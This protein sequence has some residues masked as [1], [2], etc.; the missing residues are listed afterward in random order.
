VTLIDAVE[1]ER[2]LAL[3]DGLPQ[4]IAQA[5]A[6][7]QES[8]VG[9]TSY[10]RFYKQQWSELME[11]DDH[12]AVASLPDYLN[13]S[14]WTT[15]AI[16]YQAIRDKHEATANLLLLWSFLNNKD[17]WY[18]LFTTACRSSPVAA[19][20]L[21]G[22][23]GEI[24]SNDTAFSQA[25]QLLRNYSLVE[26]VVETRSYATHPVV[27]QWAYHSQARC[28]NTE[29]SRL[30]VVTVGWSV[31]G[32]SNRDYATLQRRLLPHAQACSSVIAKN[33]PGWNYRGHEGNHEAVDEKEEQEAVLDAI[34]L[35][36]NLYV[37]QGKLSEAEQMYEWALRGQEEAFGPTHMPTLQTVNNLGILYYNQGKLG[38]A[39]QMYKRALQGKEETFG[40]HHTSTLDTVNNL[41]NLYRNQGKLAEAGQMYERALRGKKEAHGLTHTSTLQTVNNLGNLYADQGKLGEAEQMYE[42]A[43]R[44]MEQALGPN[45]TSTLNT[46][47]NLGILYKKQGKLDEAEQMYKRALRGYEEAF[48]ATH[49]LTLDLVTNLGNLYKNQGKM[50]EAERMYKQALQGTKEALGP[51][52]TSTLQALS[53]LGILY[54]NQSKLG[55]AEQMYGRALQGY[56]EALGSIHMPTLTTINNLGLLYTNQGKLGEAEQMFERA[57]RGYEEA[58]GPVHTSTLSTL[59]NLGILYH[60]QGKLSEAQQMYERALRGREEALGPTHT[61]TLDS[62]DNL[63][64]L[65]V[66]LGL[67]DEAEKLRQRVLQRYEH[68]LVSNVSSVPTEELRLQDILSLETRDH[69]D[70]RS[71]LSIDVPPSLTS[72]STLSDIP[73]IAK[74]A[75]EQFA[76]ILIGDSIM[77]P[78]FSI[79]IERAGSEKFKRNFFRLLTKYAVDLRVEASGSIQTEAARLVRSRA[80]FIVH[81]ITESVGIEETPTPLQF[82][83]SEPDKELGLEHYLQQQVEQTQHYCEPIIPSMDPGQVVTN[84]EGLIDEDDETGEPERPMLI[85]LNEVKKFMVGSGAYKQLRTNFSHFVFPP[86]E[87]TDTGSQ[88]AHTIKDATMKAYRLYWICVGHLR[89]L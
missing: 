22:W 28:F 66:N 54:H 36:G 53:N 75:A 65:Y 26:E 29:L 30:A 40:P 27:H 79:G 35:L 82:V 48:G 73:R 1:R 78:L 86:A 83:I 16:S 63:S 34:H 14:V 11:S 44:G 17:L 74:T 57:L 88:S 46:V 87:A 10:L 77:Q 19:K 13:R 76:E 85:N 60:N 67:L 20:M 43:L 56:E 49:T 70:M 64:K 31:P 84:A 2:L 62:V 12:L 50:D 68:G 18:G 39:E 5:G 37:D 80:N 47:N 45:H 69:S 21:S 9:L 41:G 15:W 42:Q 33:K 81:L 59:N 23:I 58:L 89:K 3:L 55:E 61:S 7:L 8:G 4:A 38:Q 32:I 25:M 24:A 71:V 6:Y 51:N 52:H 72:G